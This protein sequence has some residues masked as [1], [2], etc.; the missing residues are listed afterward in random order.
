M[1]A[2]RSLIVDPTESGYYHCVSRCVRRAFLCGVDHLTGRDCSHRKVWVEE[3][4]AELAQLFAL[5]VYAY[6]VMS[7]HLHVVVQLAPGAAAAWSAEDVAERWVRLF[8]VH[9]DGEPD[10]DANA[11]RRANLLGDPARVAV[12]RARLASLSWFMKCL[13]KH[14][15]THQIDV[16]L[17]RRALIA[18]SAGRGGARCCDHGRAVLPDRRSDRVGLLPLRVALRAACL[19]VRL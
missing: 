2:A 7:N 8:P 4:I 11:Q 10:A 13:R 15:D 18:G 5:N 9:V 16:F 12:C 1:T 6:A 19:P 3:R 17:Q 14:R